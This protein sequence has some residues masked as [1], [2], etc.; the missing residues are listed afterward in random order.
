M[1][2]AFELGVNLAPFLYREFHGAQLEQIIK[3]LVSGVEVTKYARRDY[4][5]MQ[6]RELR[7]GL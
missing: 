3:G 2:V 7:H 4:N 1:N 6:M 5:W